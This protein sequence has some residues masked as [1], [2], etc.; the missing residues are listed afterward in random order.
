MKILVTGDSLIARKESLKEPMLNHY[1]KKKVPGIKIINT[2]IS[3]NNT[4]DLIQRFEKDVM[5]YQGID[6]IFILIG[7]NDLAL[8]KQIPKTIYRENLQWII[9]ELKEK[10]KSDQ[11]Y[12]I[13]PPAVD[14]KKQKFRNNELIKDYINV[15]TETANSESCVVID[16]YTEIINQPDFKKIINGTVK[17][18]L[19]FGK[20]GYDLL[21]DIIIRYL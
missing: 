19:H 18:G 8:N 7:T 9:S 11:I 17:D 3:G 1:L 2:A 14:E 4:N 10:Y 6:K 16:F 21:S 13:T 5:S 15:L 20:E 12:F